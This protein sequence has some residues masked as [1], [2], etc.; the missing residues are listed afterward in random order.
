[1]QAHTMKDIPGHAERFLTARTKQELAA[2]LDEPYKRF[3]YFVYAKDPNDQYT[4][5]EISKLRGKAR[6]IDAPFTPIKHIQQNLAQILSHIYRPSHNAHAFIRDRSVVTNAQPHLRSK[7]LIKIDLVD[8]FGSI[9]F[10]RVMSLFMAKPFGFTRE[11]AIAVARVTCKDRK[12]PQGGPASPVISN[13]I[14]L[15][16]DAQINRLAKRNRCTYTRYADDITIS[17]NADS[18]PVDII[19][20]SS[21]LEPSKA[22]NHIIESNGFSINVSKL[23]LRSGNDSKV[24]TGVKVNS[25]LNTIRARVREVRAMIHAFKK[26]G[27]DKALNEH[28]SKWT[29]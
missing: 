20:S 2:A 18:L 29:D 9:N 5:Y 27:N 1:M 14:C 13:M 22:I 12:L 24:I 28:I 7:T 25:K 6:Q 17:T 4:S 16:L 11:V 21:P 15:K 26:F 10:G 3:C 8:F 19:S 23:C